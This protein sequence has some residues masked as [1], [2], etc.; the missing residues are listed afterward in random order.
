[1]TIENGSSGGSKKGG[2][3]KARPHPYLLPQEKGNTRDA[4]STSYVAGALAGS[5]QAP[6]VQHPSFNTDRPTAQEPSHPSPLPLSPLRVEGNAAAATCIRGGV[7]KKKYRVT[8]RDYQAEVFWNNTAGILVLHWA[9]QIGKSFTLAAWAVN[10]L[11]DRPGR[12]VTV[13]S[14]SRENGAEFV[15]KCAEICWQTQT[16]FETQDS[17]PGLDFDEMRFEVRIRVG[18]K[19]GR[20][21]VLAANPRTARGFSGDLILDEFAFHEDAEAIWAAAEPILASNPDFLCRIASTGNG[22]HNLFYRMVEGGPTDASCEMQ[23]PHRD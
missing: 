4:I 23:D 19:V 9:R 8:L 10:R 17:P 20:I 12:L 18:R 13:L 7:G 6:S 14:N 2:N 16:R 5:G 21:K 15:A 22:R 11:L 3:R 1:M